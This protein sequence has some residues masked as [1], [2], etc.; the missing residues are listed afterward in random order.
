MTGDQFVEW[1][2]RVLH[3]Q[4]EIQRCWF[5]IRIFGRVLADEPD[6][7]WRSEASAELTRHF[8][9]LAYFLDEPAV[10]AMEPSAP[11][12]PARRSA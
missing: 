9:R 7:E 8:R 10:T 1:S 11:G 4:A 3:V 12:R 6:A 2:E 5:M